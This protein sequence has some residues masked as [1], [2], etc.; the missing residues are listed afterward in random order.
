[1]WQKLVRKEFPDNKLGGYIYADYF[2]PSGSG[3][4]KMEPNLAF[5]IAT[6]VRYGYQLYRKAT[7]VEWESVVSAWA[8]SAKENGFDIYYNDCLQPL[9][10]IMVS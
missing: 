8:K 10:S 1:M 6:H 3:I 5:M 7:Q 9:C 2:Y 4:P